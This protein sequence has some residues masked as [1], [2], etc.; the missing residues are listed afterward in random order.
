MAQ[1]SHM[2]PE[3]GQLWLS[4]P[5]FLLVTQ[6]R[7]VVSQAGRARIEYE[8]FDDDGAPLTGPVNELLDT[9][10]WENFQPLVRRHG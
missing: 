5:P 8:L 1:I 6:V 10:W 2:Q 4:R 9:S 3:P 7:N